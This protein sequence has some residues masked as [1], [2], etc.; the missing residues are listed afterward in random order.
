MDELIENV[1]QKLDVDKK[2]NHKLAEFGL[3]KTNALKVKYAQ[4]ILTK[5][6]IIPGGVNVP[7]EKSGKNNLKS[8]DFANSGYKWL[9]Q[10][11]D[12]RHHF[13]ALINYNESVC[14]AESGSE[15]LMNAYA[16]R[17]AIYF[18]WKLYGHCLENIE[19]VKMVGCD[20]EN[21]LQVLEERKI[22]C[23]DQKTNDNPKDVAYEPILSHPAHAKVPFIADCL[24]IRQNEQYGRYIIT[25][26]DLEPG[27][28]IAI[29][30]KY[31]AILLPKLRYQRCAN[32]LKENALSLIPCEHCTGSMFC[33]T[34]CLKEAA[35]SFHPYEC[36]IIDYLHE[37]FNRFHL[38]AL[39]ATIMAFLS[40]NTID[41]LAKTVEIAARS[42]PVTA[43]TFNHKKKQQK[44]KYLQIHTFPTKQEERTNSDLFGTAIVTAVLCQKLLAGTKFGVILKTEKEQSLLMELLFRHLQI[45]RM[46]FHSISQ[47]ELQYQSAQ[48]GLLGSGVFPFCSLINHACTPNILRISFGNRMVIFVLRPI[49]KGQ[50]L[51]DN[52]G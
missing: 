40:F 48:G 45:S 3:L 28:I 22:K 9:S 38:C 36:G 43:F 35:N 6:Q 37:H 19:L 30:E 32:C 5:L 44:Q 46:Y 41:E 26:R 33:S 21:L 10:H 7:T 15:Y 50:Q 2:L 49:K 31:L 39:R 47:S 4:K 23:L 51:F 20:N 14:F 25:H 13:D 1:L 34:K 17:S 27:Q 12:S 18:D 24:D 52:Y 16:N 42:K 8:F 29:E 11:K